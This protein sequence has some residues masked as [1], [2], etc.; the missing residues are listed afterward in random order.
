TGVRG[1]K[2]WFGPVYFRKESEP[3]M[4]MAV[5]HSGRN[6][7]VTVAEVNLKLIW[8][9]ITAIKIGQTGYAYVVDD[10]GRLIAHPDISR[11][12]R[13]S[14][15]SGLPQVMAARDPQ[16]ANAG[17]NTGSGADPAA[18]VRNLDGHRVLSASAAIP[19]LGWLVFVEQPLS[20]A[21]APLY[22]ALL[23]T[24]LLLVLGLAV[25]VLA[26]LLLARRMTGPI[27]ELDAGAARIGA[28]ALGHR[29]TVDTGDELEELAERFNTMAADLQSSYADLEKKVE[30]RTAEL[31]EALDQQTATAEA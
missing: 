8:D 22:T 12:L 24:G 17:A 2:V 13:N 4:T 18:I 25:A 26:G 5:A 11:V 3:Y 7:G 15:L 9:V 20:E 14:D 27:R 31:T 29:I 28:G 1:K 16:G 21:L 19:K 30:D 10:K 23:N 6:A